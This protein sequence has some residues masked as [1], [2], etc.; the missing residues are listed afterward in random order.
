MHDVPGYRVT[1]PPAVTPVPFSIYY[2]VWD[3]S[4]LSLPGPAKAMKGTRLYHEASLHKSRAAAPGLTAP[5]PQP[6]EMGG[7]VRQS[8]ARP[9]PWPHE[10][11]A[12]GNRRGPG[13]GGSPESFFFFFTSMFSLVRTR[14]W[15]GIVPNLLTPRYLS[16]LHGV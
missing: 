10:P 14:C 5:W 6:R 4:P 16:L 7:G 11:A 13:R 9:R 12:A 8:A 15:R 3:C 1:K 2:L